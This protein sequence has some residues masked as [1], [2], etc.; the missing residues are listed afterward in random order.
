MREKRTTTLQGRL[1]DAKFP[2][3]PD[4]YSI[5]KQKK[6]KFIPY[7]LIISKHKYYGIKL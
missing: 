2:S 5:R 4:G 7:H 1:H 3:F 6:N